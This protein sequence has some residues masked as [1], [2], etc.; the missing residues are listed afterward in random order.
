MKEIKKYI[1]AREAD[2]YNMAIKKRIDWLINLSK[3]HSEVYC[4]P[5]AYLARKRYTLKHPTMV[6]VVK[7]PHPKGA[8]L[9]NP[10]IGGTRPCPQRGRAIGVV[11]PV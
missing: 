2:V 3:R 7:N 4:T 11:P 10:P 8:A 5:E 1:N 6:V 9:E